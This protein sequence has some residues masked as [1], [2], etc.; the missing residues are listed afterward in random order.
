VDLIYEAEVCFVFVPGNGVRF[1]GGAV[2]EFAR[3]GIVA[4]EYRGG[5]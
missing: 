1:A 2:P 5:E 4:D 3:T